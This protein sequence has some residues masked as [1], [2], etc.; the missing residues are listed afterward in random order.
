[1]LENIDQFSFYKMICLTGSG[2]GLC[3]MVFYSAM[4][5][6]GMLNQEQSDFL[7]NC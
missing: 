5:F 3:S 6:P 1:M 4:E 7:T 2:S